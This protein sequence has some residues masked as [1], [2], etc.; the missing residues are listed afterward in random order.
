VAIGNNYFEGDPE[1]QVMYFKEC[2]GRSGL[3][4]GYTW[5]SI[6]IDLYIWRRTLDISDDGDCT[7]AG[8]SGPKI[9]YFKG[10]KAR[11]VMIKIPHGHLE[12]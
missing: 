10:S 4:A 7:A 11:A 8:G 9:F 6:I 2:T 5:R 3:Q 12:I 1:S